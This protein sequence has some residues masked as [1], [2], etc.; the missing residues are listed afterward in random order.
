MD[1][2]ANVIDLKFVEIRLINDDKKK[3]YVQKRF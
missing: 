2:L 3:V 1:I